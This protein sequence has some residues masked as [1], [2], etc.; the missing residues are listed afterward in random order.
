[1]NR[2]DWVEYMRETYG[3]L[4]EYPWQRYPQD[5]VFRHPENR[6]WFALLMRVNKAKLGLKGN[7]TAD[8]LTLKADPAMVGS[9]CR[10]EGIFPGYH[11]NKANWVT[12]WLGGMVPKQ[13]IEALLE[14][15]F[16]KTMPKNRN[17]Q[18]SAP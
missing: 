11:M 8:V 12:I 14:M 5:A 2:E 17:K 10:E 1:M 13:Q 7:G 4:P 9:L 18:R 6:K 15:S 16:Q 3:V